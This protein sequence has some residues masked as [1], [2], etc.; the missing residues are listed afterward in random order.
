MTAPTVRS[1]K[2][3]LAALTRH[4]PGDDP[5]LDRARRDLD[6]ARAADMTAEAAR[7][8]RGEARS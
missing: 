1:A 8:L 6:A 7:L 2:A 4:R 5:A 3:R